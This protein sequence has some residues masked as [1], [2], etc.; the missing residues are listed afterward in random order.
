M[1]RWCGRERHRICGCSG[2]GNVVLRRVT[3]GGLGVWCWFWWAAGDLSAGWWV[4]G[5]V[6]TIIGFIHWRSGIPGARTASMFT[7]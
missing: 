3:H 2:S 5:L 1:C 4:K 6:I 7:S